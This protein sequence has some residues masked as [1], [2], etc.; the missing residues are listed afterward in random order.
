VEAGPTPDYKNPATS[1][2]PPQPKAGPGWENHTGGSTY[3]EAPA[4][5]APA[6]SAPAT[7]PAPS[8]PAPAATP[9][10]T[11]ASG[12]NTIAISNFTFVPATL[13]VAPGTTVTWTNKDNVFH[14]VKFSDQ[15]SASLATG[16]SFSRTFSQ[17]G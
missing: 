2:S 1:M 7:T 17:P 5:T 14:T 3:N 10:A 4:P 15:T 12:G 6:A 13:T 16:A 9:P 8:A 11:A